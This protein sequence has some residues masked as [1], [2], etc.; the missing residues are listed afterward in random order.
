M[1]KQLRLL[2]TLLLL[3]VVS[4]G[5]AEEETID[6]STKGY[7]NQE[8]I[9]SVEGSAFSISF[10]KGTNSNAP[11]YFNTGAAIRVYGGNYFTVSSSNT[12]T[13]ITLTFSSGEGSN[14]IT[15]NVGTFTSPTWSGSAQEV[16]FTI[17][18]TSGHRRIKKITVTYTAGA[19][20]KQNATV[21]IGANEI[22]VGGTTTVTTD[23]PALTLTSSNT[24]VATVSGNTISGVAAGITNITA[25]WAENDTYNGG[26]KTFTL[27]VKDADKGTESNP[28]TVAEALALINNLNGQTSWQVYVKGIVSGIVTA[29]NSQYGNI[30][31]NISDDGTTEANQLQ[32][33]RGLGLN[34]NQFTSENDLLAGDQVVVCGTLTMYNTT[35]EF[36]ANNY[37][38]SLIR[39]GGK[40]AAGLAYEVKSL[41]KYTTDAAFTN[42]LT[43]PNGLTVSYD[44]SNPGVATVDANGQVTIGTAGTTTITATSAED[45]TYYAGTAS[46]TLTVKEQKTYEEGVLFDETFNSLEGTG[47]RDG[48]FSGS[49]GSG[50]MATA[51]FDE[52]NWTWT[53]TGTGAAYQSV[54]LGTGSA[55]GAITTRSIALNGNGTLT[56]SVAGWG[57]AKT[58]TL[59]VTATG[60]TLSGDTEVTATNGE[61]TTHSVTITGATGDLVLTFTMQRGFID[62]IKVAE[63]AALPTVTSPTFS[64]AAG[65]VAY[66]TN[67][68]ITADEGCIINY[69]VDGTDPATSTTATMTEGNTATVSITQDLT[70]R[71]IA[72]DGD[73]NESSEATATYTV[74]RPAAPVFTPA[75]GTVAAGTQV[76]I[77][78][79]G[80]AL[81]MYTT[82]GTTPS[83]ANNVGEIYSTPITVNTTTTIKAIAIDDNE[84]ESEVASATYTV[85][86]STPSNT[87]YRKVT[88]TADLTDGEYLIVY[89]DGSLAFNGGL[90]TLDAV[91]NTINVT[92][93][94]DEIASNATV[95]A[96]TFTIDMT[97]GT[98][99][100]KSGFYIGQ[101]SNNNGLASSETTAYTHNE[102]S[103]NEGDPTKHAE[104]VS[105]GG[106]F[107]RYNAA[108]NQSRFRY[109]KSS[110]YAGQQA[111]H[112]YKKVTESADV[113][114]PVTKIGYASMYYQNVNLIVPAGVKAS[115]YVVTNGK[116]TESKAYNTGDIIP[117]GTAVVIE[118][119]TPSTE[120]QTFEFTATTEAGEAPTANMLYGS[121][122]EITD[123]EAG[124]KYYILST[125]K[126][127]PN[128]EPG[129]Y[130][131]QGT[132]GDKVTSAPNK[133]YLKIPADV[134]AGAKGFTFSGET[135]G[136]TTIDGNDNADADGHWYT[137]D[138][139]RLNT[140][141][142]QKGLYI[143]NGKKIVVK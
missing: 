118:A 55:T 20:D 109:Y 11:K 88:A 63:G 4:V 17:G 100:S 138:G 16:T 36:A 131:Q 8:A 80:A 22:N 50:S 37:L 10:N 102:I 124:Y 43:N 87:V 34:G 117:A 62:D 53:S 101:N 74:A 13:A 44:S 122:T 112:L 116:L 135:T 121:D 129:F 77:T 93:A 127:D 111:I 32:A 18:G 27:T 35:P 26:S 59:T 15:T 126:D 120:T 94:N 115:A 52:E 90:E 54:K 132:Q 96:A 92:I 104:I 85:E 133:A 1:K 31:Y 82:D 25:T 42:P 73:A 143:H 28:Y 68:T 7:A 128:G 65:E 2:L 70:I 19:S 137:I 29:Y 105:S 97:A 76:T 71:A 95:D 64:P 66:G 60:G 119:L 57:D 91:S 12:I 123:D 72:L 141:P 49:I 51:N 41:T 61:W 136:I 78:A 58:N 140:M 5:W 14:A 21:A 110:S 24:N 79:E 103:I 23:G 98:I 84:L 83:Y 125:P 39:Q 3:S 47:G 142:T 48:S 6:F 46:Y 107:L 113:T 45:D 38:V 75:A 30:S 130:W 89:E 56:F 99:K 40:E 106:A 134:A 114:M 69:T 33:Y 9:E 139:Q 81:I 108:S 86:S 67:V